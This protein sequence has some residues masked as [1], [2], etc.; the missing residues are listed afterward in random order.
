M[1]RFPHF[2]PVLLLTALLLFAPLPSAGSESEELLARSIAYHAPD[3]LWGHE[4]LQLS[5]EESRP[6]GSMRKTRVLIDPHH[7][8]FEWWS[9]RGDDLLEG[10]LIGSECTVTLNGSTEIPDANSPPSPPRRM[11]MQTIENLTRSI[12][13]LTRIRPPRIR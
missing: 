3:G 7:E 9:E 10:S 8:R 1:S 4:P 2:F 11:R 6:D 13:A 12:Q 5:F